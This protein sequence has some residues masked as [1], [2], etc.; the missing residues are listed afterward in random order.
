[1]QARRAF[2][3]ETVHLMGGHDALRFC[4]NIYENAV[5]ISADYYAFDD[6]ATAEFRVGGGF[7][8]EEGRHGLLLSWRASF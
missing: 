4:S 7:F 6:L 2:R 8:F 5:S 1:M 3:L